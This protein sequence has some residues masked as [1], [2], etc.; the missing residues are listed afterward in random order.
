LAEM[1]MSSAKLQF[2]AD[3]LNL[4]WSSDIVVDNLCQSQNVTITPRLTETKKFLMR[5]LGRKR[6]IWPE[7]ANVTRISE[8][9]PILE[10]EV[11]FLWLFLVFP[12]L[13]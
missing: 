8:N 4:E 12:Y 5:F 1:R 2:S 10:V 7:N 11:V 6:N 3:F 13:E 9:M